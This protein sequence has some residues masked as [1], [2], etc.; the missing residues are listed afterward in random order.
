MN[1][2]AQNY[3]VLGAITVDSHSVLRRSPTVRRGRRTNC[4]FD[5][6]CPGS[7]IF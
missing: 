4:P 3:V 5:H 1:A 6:Q 7:V 2:N